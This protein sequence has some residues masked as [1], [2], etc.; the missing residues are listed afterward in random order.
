MNFHFVTL[1]PQLIAPWLTTS[2]L[3]KALNRGLF[4]FKNYSLRDFS[5]NPHRSVDD[6]A[7]GGGGGMVLSVAP[8]AK[9]VEHIRSQNNGPFRVIYFSPQGLPLRTERVEGAANGTVCDW[10]LVCGHYEGV[11]RRF[12]DRW[13]DEEISLGDFV[14]SGG[15]LPALAFADAVIRQCEGT[16]RIDGA[17]EESFSLNDHGV[18]LLEYPHY[19]RPEEISGMRVPEILLSGDHLAIAE[20]RLQ[21]SREL[22]AERR[23][24]LLRIDKETNRSL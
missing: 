6:Y 14:L 11:D 22:T 4:S 23:P 21:R 15:E 17:A 5:D 2:I 19:T 20:W 13:V 24:D 10:V 9:A 1:F 8:L 7:Y 16:L 18:R 3:G 12:I